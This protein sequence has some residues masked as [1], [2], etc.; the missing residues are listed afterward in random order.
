M[1][2]L[3]ITAC[4]ITSQCSIASLRRRDTRLDLQLAQGRVLRKR[5][6]AK[7]RPLQN[8]RWENKRLLLTGV[9]R[10]Q[11]SQKESPGPNSARWTLFSIYRL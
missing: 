3:F 11:V 1:N 10:L 5:L 8:S 7:E 2:S 6:S 9:K 4:A